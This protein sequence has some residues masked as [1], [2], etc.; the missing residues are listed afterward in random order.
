MFLASIPRPLSALSSLADRA[1]FSDL[2]VSRLGLNV[3]TPMPTTTSSG[4]TYTTDSPLVLI[5][6]G[7]ARSWASIGTAKSTAI[8]RAI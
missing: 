7:I 2:D 8:M 6:R 3:S 1:S 5:V 4:L